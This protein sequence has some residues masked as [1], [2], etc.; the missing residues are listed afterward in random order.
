MQKHKLEILERLLLELKNRA[1]Y[2]SAVLSGEIVFIKKKKADFM[3][4]LKQ[5]GFTPLPGKGKSAV[6]DD[7]EYLLSMSIGTLTVESV[8]KLL[9][10]K[11]EKTR[12]FEILK[13][14]PPTSMWMT[15]LDELEKKL[16][17]RD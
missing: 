3:I 9:N 7:Y 11:E 4:E 12:E 8:E 5:K 16:D 2:I 6:E 13:A 14:T 17:V 15:D 10:E 1:N